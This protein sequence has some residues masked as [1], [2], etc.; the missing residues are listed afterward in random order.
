MDIIDFVIPQRG[1]SP[2]G[3]V[4]APNGWNVAMAPTCQDAASTHFGFV[5]T[6]GCGQPSSNTMTAWCLNGQGGA[7]AQPLGTP[8][9]PN[10]GRAY[11]GYAH[12]SL[13]NALNVRGTMWRSIVDCTQTSSPVMLRVRPGTGIPRPIGDFP[14]DPPTPVPWAVI[15]MLGTGILPNSDTRTNGQES[16]PE[17]VP[18]AVISPTRITTAPPGHKPRPPGPGVKERKMIANLPPGLLAKAINAATESR[19]A[20][21]AI[22]DAL[23]GKIRKDLW[24]KYAPKGQAGVI[25]EVPIHRKI[26]ALY[27]HAGE[28][29]VGKAIGNLLMNQAE[30]KAIGKANKLLQKGYRSKAFGGRAVGFG[31][32]PA[33]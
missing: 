26:E 24:R 25:P 17:P 19:D 29:D 6:Y 31:T 20:V 2:I 16:S 12:S 7:S 9:S 15:P 4:V 33:F 18:D 22:Y 27:Q 23:P 32:G 30:D 8:T 1:T 28:I 14:M 11:I 5:N 10:A 13:P 21:N 3:T